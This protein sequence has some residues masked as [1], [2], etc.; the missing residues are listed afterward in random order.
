MATTSKRKLPKVSQYVKNV[1]KSVAY[2]SITSVSNSA[3]GISN[4]MEENEDFFKE[5][6]SGLKDFKGSLRKAEKSIRDT[7]IY[8]A[9]ELGI[10]NTKDDLRTGNLYN[11]SREKEN[12]E[13]LLGIDDESLGLDFDF[14]VSYDDDETESGS[15]KSAPSTAVVFAKTMQA[16]TNATNTIAA[17]GTD[18]V[19]K[20]GRAS[21]KL[22]VAHIERST[23]TLHS[24]LG[25]V[26]SSV[27]R[28]NQMLNGPMMEHLNNSKTY[29]ETTTKLLQ[30]QT[31]MMQEMLEMQRNLYA[32]SATEN[33]DTD[34]DKILGYDGTINLKA[35]GKNIKDNVTSMLESMGFMD[36]GVNL[37]M[38]LAQ[39]P[40][41]FM[42]D[43][44][45]DGFMPKDFKKHLKGFDKGIS[46][47]FSQLITKANMRTKTIDGTSEI[48]MKIAEVLGISLKDKKSINTANYNKGPVPFDGITRK[49]IIEV[50]PGYLARIEAALTGRE[51]R[52]FD[53][54][55]GKWKNAS[56][57]KN[58]F[59]AERKL[60][61]RTANSALFAD[62]RQ[63]VGN[64]RSTN[65]K[66]AKALEARI[67]NAATVIY[68]DGGYF[69]PSIR[70]RQK[71]DKYKRTSTGSAWKK[72]GFASKDQFDAFISTLSDD[73][74]RDLAMENM[75][76]RES[77]SRRMEA[78][79]ANG[80][81]HNFLFNDTFD[82]SDPKSRSAGHMRRNILTLSQDKHG[83]SIFDY[84]RL[85]LNAIGGAGSKYSGSGGPTGPRIRL[86]KTSFTGRYRV[87]GREYTDESEGDPRFGDDEGWEEAQ[88]VWNEQER[89]KKEKTAD[90]DAVESW[91]KTKL[92][93]SS[94]GRFFMKI[95]GG[96]SSMLSA[97][98]KYTTELLQKADEN[99]FRMM[100]G[101]HAI[102]D[103]DEEV[104]NV[105]EFIINKVKKSF[106]DLGKW[107]KTKL[108]LIFRPFWEEK[109]KPF[110]DKYGKPV[111]DE[112]KN[113]GKRA[114]KRTKTAFSNTFGKA[115]G[116]ASEKLRNGGVVTADEVEDNGY[117]PFQDTDD[118]YDNI[119][120][121]AHGR[122]VTKRGLTMISP[123]E[124]IIPASDNPR[125]LNRM[126]RAEKRDKNRILRS[127]SFRDIA[128]NAKGTVDTEALKENLRKI[129]NE[130]KG[131]EKGAKV[132]AGGI[133]GL[134]AGIL[135]GNPLL[136]AMAGAGLSI[137]DNSE[138]LKNIVFGNEI[139]G[140]REGGLIPKKI[141]DLFSK[142]LPDMGDYGIAGGV[143]G[144]LTPFG[145]LGGAA[146]GA[147]IGYLKH[148]DGFKKFIFGEEGTDNEG[149]ISREVYDKFIAHV[150]KSAPN[151][152]IGAGLGILAGPFGLLGNAA[153]GAGAG[154]ISTTNSFHTFLFGDEET[155]ERGMLSAFQEGFLEPAKEKLLEFTVDFKEYS[156]KH[157]IGPMKDFLKPARQMLINVIKGTGDKIADN[158]NDMLERVLGL[159]MADFLQEK[160][161]KPIS[162]LVFGAVKAPYKIG[163]FMLSVP[164]RALGALGNTMR[165]RQ[166]KHGTAYDMS[167]SERLAWR[168]NH[169]VRFNPLSGDRMLEEDETL[170][171]M[172]TDDLS[173]LI[174]GA[175][176]GLNS[177]SKLQKASGK[178]RI[179]VSNSV[180]GFFNSKDSSGHTLY[181][182][183]NYK[184]VEKLTEIA[185]EGNK[186]K[187]FR[188]IDKI[189]GLTDE[190]KAR[191]KVSIEDKI[192]GAKIANETMANA[193]IATDELDA[194]MSKLLGRKFKGKADRRQLMNAAEA[195]LKARRKAAA[196]KIK[197]D[198]SGVE[199]VTDFAAF[200]AKK[201]DKVISSINTAAEYLH[202]LVD[203]SYKNTDPP[204]SSTDGGTQAT[205]ADEDSQASVEVRQAEAAEEAEEDN[206][207]D[208]IET[209][210]NVLT[211]IKDKLIGDDKKKDKPGI[212][213]KI[214][215]Y[216]GKG[217]KFIGM[218]AVGASLAGHA[219]EW[220]RKNVWPNLKV[221]L[222]GDESTGE[223]GL[224][225]KI[226]TFFTG[227]Y[228]KSIGWLGE[229]L[230]GAHE[231]LLSK[232]GFKGILLNDI[233]PG[234][235]N[236]LTY[237]LN[238][239]G[240]PI[241]S[242]FLKSLPSML[243]GL[244]RS[245]LEGIR[246]AFFNNEVPS[247]AIT[248]PDSGA[249]DALSKFQ[250]SSNST[251]KSSDTSNVVA[252]L[253]YYE[254]ISESYMGSS[255]SIR[256]T[257]SAIDRVDAPERPAF[258]I[259]GLLGKT[260]RTNTVEIDENG[261]SLTK[262]K[263]RN[264]TDS[265]GSIVFRAANRNFLK[266]FSGLKIRTD[267]I[268]DV[269]KIAASGATKIVTPGVMK[270]IGGIGEMALA[271]IKGA[272]NLVR[273]AG[274]FGKAAYEAL[275]EAT[276]D[277]VDDI[278]LKGMA[279]V[280]KE[281]ANSKIGA[282][283]MKY[284]AKMGSKEVTREM[285]EKAIIAIGDKLGKELIEKGASKALVNILGKFTPL[286][287]IT[288][289]WDFAWGFD[290][291]YTILGVA[292]GDSYVVN[293]AQKCCCG[294]VNLITNYFTLGIIPA[295][296]I[297][298]L[299]VDILFPIFGIS[300][301][302]LKKARANADAFMTEWNASKPPDERIDNLED[303]NNKDKWWYKLFVA[304]N[305]KKSS[306]STLY[307]DSA[308]P[309]SS[310]GPGAYIKNKDTV[311]T[312][313]TY[314][315]PAMPYAARGRARNGRFVGGSRTSHLYQSDKSIASI[316]YGNSTIGEAGCAPVAAVNLLNS[317]N[318]TGKHSVQDAAKY[319]ET[320]GMLT[321]EGT[322]INYFNSYLGSKG[323]STV[324]SDNR[325]TIMR[326]LQ[327]GNH[328]IMLGKDNKKNGPFGITP[329]YI[330]AKGIAANG[331][332]IAEDPDLPHSSIEYSA[333]DVMKSM[334]TSVIANTRNVSKIQRGNKRTRFGSGRATNQVY[335]K[336]GSGSSGYS[337]TASTS[338]SLG[339][340]SIIAVAMSQI[341]VAEE[342]NSNKVKYC[343]VY[344]GKDRREPWCCIFVWWVFNQAGAAKLFYNGGKTA[345]CNTLREFYKGQGRLSDNPQ[346]G[347]IVFFN[348]SGNWSQ[349]KHVGI[350][351]AV[352]DDNTITTIEGNTS[353]T[354]QTNG[355]CVEKK[356]RKMKD[357][358]GCA[359]PN[360]PY[361]F[362]TA[363]VVDMARYGDHTDYEAIALGAASASTNNQNSTGT[364]LTALTNLGTSMVKSMYGIDAYNALFGTV[365]T[366]NGNTSSIG[367][368][369]GDASGQAIWD[370]LR[371]KGYTN[372]GTAGIMGNLYAESALRSN[373]LQNTYEKKLGSDDVYTGKVNN[374]SYSRSRFYNDKAGYGL[375][376]WTASSRK[377]KLYDA[378]IGQ[379]IPIDDTTGQINYLAR[380]LESDFSATNNLLKSTNS[381]NAASDAMLHDFE[382][383]ANAKDKE[384][385]RRNYSNNMLNAYGS[386]R[387]RNFS[388][389]AARA[390]GQFRSGGTGIGANT[391]RTVSGAAPVD[392]QTFLQT[393]V[394]ILMSIADN[395][396]LL[397]KIFELLS[398]N[399]GIKIDKKEIEAISRSNSEKAK[400]AMNEI[401]NRTANG[402]HSQLDD[403]YTNYLVAAMS[404]IASE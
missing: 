378:L 78:L 223:A 52:F 393:I 167:A 50:I 163:R 184:T 274:G 302:E 193:N 288:M 130:N 397:S 105:F 290:N 330:T 246:G 90:K 364:L 199:T 206:T 86:N 137:L 44:M 277:N 307:T 296:T 47:M 27:E 219:S 73:T 194:K 133:V 252:N 83:K 98:M 112:I 138:T 250:T 267:K 304:P 186:K 291:A 147:G 341:G 188:Y 189:D 226:K 8:K 40:L 150:K 33:K 204:G 257:Q 178:A 43:F 249:S 329:H 237:A 68:D 175:R 76:A 326:A 125:E 7:N 117:I 390:L 157:I 200:Y 15:S 402:Y 375:A 363:S 134:G 38:V 357:V 66:A 324:N 217:A 180:S 279:R 337:A 281:I 381:V 221:T 273:N 2:A 367:T 240:G 80:G 284:A 271:G 359:H 65:P 254:N 45:A 58:S 3:P 211:D 100:F 268:D 67:R 116:A 110:Y 299:V 377:K 245:I 169:K 122:L 234:F 135:L 399:L 37:P 74:I 310:Q 231:W 238:N 109:I 322:D 289:A 91:I 124:M 333:K 119:V 342:G 101:D 46:S 51:E 394:T 293:F 142:A 96:V 311:N 316:R 16:A 241:I 111:V 389:G 102:R 278:A 158:T 26:Y 155:G 214:L 32:A 263:D 352:N 208:N 148:S 323:I 325:V 239:L 203:P 348:F 285:V 59:D 88:A 259:G 48:V 106:E 391:S 62:S 4:F 315:D 356:T 187:A 18:L 115:F 347:D 387:N 218:T 212:L 190:E 371:N 82:G 108:D 30:D 404:A 153:F 70:K 75:R 77:Y 368:S 225:G 244:G 161:F 177:V 207:D 14:Q 39:A 197:P 144:L 224:F 191:L 168:K 384:T 275:Q 69:N 280:F 1:G 12:S 64:I 251:I 173:S 255:N 202:M 79:E 209:T 60:S 154:L 24:G 170:A 309:W 216:I 162:K 81:L 232:G 328:V 87:A 146:I 266:G 335:L 340:D 301:E 312:S 358:V 321:D 379:G 243:K 128:L 126:L 351:I 113:M 233:V 17:R 107:F 94:V 230:T 166:I 265:I 396:A 5:L 185:Q 344:Y 121:S 72:Y 229:K 71:G 22:M 222:M 369:T 49:T 314:S 36:M 55:L 97:P 395:T 303:F 63:M 127:S 136:G 103:G 338:T 248:V 41:K 317:I 297:M 380:E 25:A 19:I 313:Y 292:K 56:D 183:V 35:Y 276:K 54:N 318:R 93:R 23:A 172:G 171:R 10:K 366:A 152:L 247:D 339:P 258:G 327:S 373:N 21:T 92:E 320:N 114:A 160:V 129:F 57:I 345:S 362:D 132:G 350:I 401:L 140:Q 388:G 131:E 179:A 319:A 174:A 31:A 143:L 192:D 104:G 215:S 287:L 95:S 13:S 11:T 332:I 286:A 353:S 346:V 298:D 403:K 400:H 372:A 295:D 349:P 118:F 260:E 256:D 29:F 141:Q 305:K 365:D 34:L 164:T 195:E 253:K 85:I 205:G 6:Y 213:T 269:A 165:S 99:L 262:Y 61:I 198:G 336:D 53:S 84:L 386:G 272:K 242:M 282:S 264:T 220:F 283:I 201:T 392:Y 385:Q 120:E 270:K 28:V 196:A 294:I 156:D 145:P 123:G 261:N 236:G 9:V 227:L 20:S 354:N 182:R 42:L 382:R 308:M 376:Q 306:T 374:K 176:S 398:E 151:M 300:A 383:P 331:N 355:G 235:I 360:Y 361:K 139:N 334:I 343:Q 89:K 149:L 159:P 228:E 210:A 181:N 370:A